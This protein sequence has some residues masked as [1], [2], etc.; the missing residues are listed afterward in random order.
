MGVC[1]GPIDCAHEGEVSSLAR[2]GG[3]GEGRWTHPVEDER[4]ADLLPE[5]VAGALVHEPGDERED[6][7]GEEALRAR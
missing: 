5:L 1:G 3:G 2:S 7:A 6:G 4:D